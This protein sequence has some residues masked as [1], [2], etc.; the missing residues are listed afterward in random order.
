[1]DDTREMN[2]ALRAVVQQFHAPV[3]CDIGACNGA[4]AAQLASWCSHPVQTLLMVE[5]D[6]RN[7]AYME[8]NWLP[9]GATLVPCAIGST[10]REGVLHLS[11]S[12]TRYAFGGMWSVSSTMRTPK[13]HLTEFPFVTYGTDV[14]VRVRSLDSLCREHGLRGFDMLWVDIEG[15]ERDLIEGGRETLA[16]SRYLFTEKWSTELY[17]G[18]ATRDELVAMLPGW[19]VAGEWSFDMLFRNDRVQ[20]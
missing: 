18:M 12:K 5:P 6:P 10:D 11:D 20:A 1:M 13:Q 8:K 19:S 17:A 9:K 7:I 2:A 3:L 14:P 4:T 16:R 15:S